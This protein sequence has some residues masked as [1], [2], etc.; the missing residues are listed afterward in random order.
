MTESLNDYTAFLY[1]LLSILCA[2]LS[3]AVKH[4]SILPKRCKKIKETE[5]LFIISI[6]F[7]PNEK[8]IYFKIYAYTRL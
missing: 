6:S 4:K 1:I 3:L 7:S 2:N 5:T 8:A